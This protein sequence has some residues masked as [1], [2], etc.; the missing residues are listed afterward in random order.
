VNPLIANLPG[1]ACALV[2]ALVLIGASLALIG[3]IGLV[4]LET[5]YRRVHAPTLGVSLGAFTTLAGSMVFF[6]VAQGRLVLHE[7]L[8]GLFISLTTPITFM[9][10]VRAALHRDR[11]AGSGEVPSRA[12]PEP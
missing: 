10:L 9:L 3:S 11:K 7:L 1:W 6:S 5:F 8:I 2:A 4:R 12:E